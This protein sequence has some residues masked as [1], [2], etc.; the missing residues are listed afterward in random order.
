MPV[1]ST[2]T[3]SKM[4]IDVW[5]LLPKSQD[6]S[7]TIDQAIAN[8]ISTHNADNTSHLGPTESL[9]THRSDTVVDHPAG[10]VLADKLSMTEVFQN[11]S[12]ESI[13][14]FQ[15]DGNV[16]IEGVSNVFIGVGFGGI[17]DSSMFS[18]RVVNT[19]HLNFDDDFLFQTTFKMIPKAG[20]KLNIGMCDPSNSVLADT[21]G[22]YFYSDGTTFYAR[23]NTG[24]FDETSDPFSIGSGLL[25]CF[26]I[27]NTGGERML[28]FFVNGAEVYSLDTTGYTDDVYEVNYLTYRMVRTSGDNCSMNLLQLYYSNSV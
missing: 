14:G 13:D 26:R 18:E 7:T 9:E 23:V 11:V 3:L 22:L 6:D 21:L 16:S 5:G 28:R 27:Q 15:V 19:G 20:T 2:G 24:T 10:S 25:T 17:N 1:I 8:A 4:S 12:F